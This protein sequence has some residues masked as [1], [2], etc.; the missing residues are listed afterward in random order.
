VERP[1]GEDALSEGPDQRLGWIDALRGYAILGVV[2]VHSGLMFRDSGIPFG[3]GQ[4][5]V[6]LFF[7]V[8]A[9]TLAL[10]WAERQEPVWAFYLRRLFRIVPM[11]WL[12]LAVYV[13]WSHFGYAV[14]GAH[15][16]YG[17]WQ[18]LLT[19]VLLQ[20]LHID[21]LNYV[22]PGDWSVSVELAF[23][24]VFPFIMATITSSKR[25]LLLLVIAA[26]MSLALSNIDVTSFWNLSKI[27]H[28]RYREFILISPP[29]H[30]V[31]FASGIAAYWASAQSNSD[32][33][34]TGELLVIATLCNLFWLCSGGSLSAT[35]FSLCFGL[36]VFC[37]ASGA[38]RWLDLRPIRHL[39]RISYS[40]Y[41][42]H[43]LMIDIVAWLIQAI[44]PDLPPQLKFA[45]V[46]VGVLS[47]SFLICTLTYELIERRFIRLCSRLVSTMYLDR[48]TLVL[49][50]SARTSA[51]NA[52]NT[53]TQ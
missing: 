10:S 29:V 38:G 32:K 43:F 30:L 4:V 40:V 52:G 49:P 21:V 13:A 51:M 35:A 20:G 39:G 19:A 45:V 33:R 46:L 23:Y 37:M 12:A 25:A 6:E 16:P 8:S 53:A 5:G 14:L 31:A 48:R 41:L 3:W 11:F 34:L 18:I 2:F 47:T 50:A 42:L 1:T 22:V 9:F 17:A 15:R 24:A 26:L 27:D 28:T 44:A 36:I 7:V